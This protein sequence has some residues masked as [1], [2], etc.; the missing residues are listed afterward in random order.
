MN[1]LISIIAG[2]LGAWGGAEG[3][4]K[5]WRRIGIPLI[6]TLLALFTIK[7]WW[8]L[9]IMSL[10]GVLSL[11]YGMPTPD[12]PKPSKLGKFFYRLFKN[13]MWKATI[14]TRATLGLLQGL[15][16]LSVPII[17]GNWGLYGIVCAVLVL[18][19]AVFGGDAIIKNEGMFSFLGKKLLWEE[20][21]IHAVLGLLAT[22][23][24]LV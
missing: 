20:W 21:I 15:A 10:A 4:S 7:N 14:A 23:L 16:F 18:V 1:N 19:N 8:V 22:I 17:K 5:A 6:L 24:I 12:D 11:G 3:T 13:N 9:T 2:L